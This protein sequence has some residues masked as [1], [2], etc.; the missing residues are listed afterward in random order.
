MYI[1]CLLEKIR[2]CST[3]PG[4]ILNPSQPPDIERTANPEGRQQRI[5]ES[6]LLPPRTMQPGAPLRRNILP[7]SP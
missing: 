6:F 4:S 2:F 5:L 1:L 3:R 7:L